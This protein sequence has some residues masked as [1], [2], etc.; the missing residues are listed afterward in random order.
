MKA[1]S[2]TILLVLWAVCSAAPLI[3]KEMIE[4]VKETASWNVTEYE[5]NIFRG[6]TDD[7]IADNATPAQILSRNLKGGARILPA[8]MP[9]LKIDTASCIHDV[10]EQRGCVGGSFAFAVAGMLSDR[11][12][13]KGKDYGWLSTMELLSCDKGNYGCAGGWPLWAANYTAINGLVDEKCYPYTGNNE[14][15]P[16]KCKDS[17]DWNTARPCKCKNLKTLRTIDD[18]KNALVNG[19]VAVTFEAYDDFFIYKSGIYCHKEGSFKRLLS[20]R[21]V[22]MVTSPEPYI[23]IAMSYGT[24]FGEAGYV[25]MCLTCCGLFNKYEKGNVACDVA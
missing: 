3:T 23:R 7:E 8:P 15:C 4:R 9:A 24:T 14:D 2:L 22:E 6:V 25:R 5:E 20:G 21:A 16:K 1:L 19:P 18:V 17:Q 10:R 13:M 11:C 12:C